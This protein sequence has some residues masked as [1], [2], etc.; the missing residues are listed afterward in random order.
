MKDA[1][2]LVRA[3]MLGIAG[4]LIAA[5]AAFAIPITYNQE[6]TATGSLNGVQFNDTSVILSLSGDTVNVEQPDAISFQ[7]LGIATVEVGGG[8][9]YTFIYPAGVYLD[10]GDTLIGFGTTTTNGVPDQY[11][12]AESNPVFATYD[13]ATAIGPIAGTPSVWGPEGLTYP[14]SGGTLELDSTIGLAAFSATISPTPVPEPS[15]WAMMALGFA[16]LS[17]AGYRASRKSFALVT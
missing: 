3:L 16:G 2:S 7:I 15:T 12:L 1:K 6:V 10:T 11:V 8:P 14:T 5:T 13:L 17:L 4:A 9:T